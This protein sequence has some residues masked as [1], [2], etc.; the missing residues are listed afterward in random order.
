MKRDNYITEVETAVP[1][2]SRI[3]STTDLK[4]KITHVNQQFCDICGYTQ[5]ELLGHGHNIVRHPQMPKAAFA[6]LWHDI[7]QGKNWMGL[8]KNRRKDGGYYWVNAFITPIRRAG[9]IFEYQSVRTK[10]DKA[11]VQRA[12]A[13]YADIEKGKLPLPKFP[14]SLTAKIGLPWGIS[15]ALLLALPFVSVTIAI[16][17]VILSLLLMSWSLVRLS[18]RCTRLQKLSDDVQQSKLMQAIYTGDTDIL[19]AV[20]LSLR[21]QKAEIVAITA[22]ID[23]TSD[24]LNANLQS[25]QQSVDANHRELSQ[26]AL[27]L[28][29][30][31]AAI[32]Q[33][34]SAIAEIAATSSNT[35]SDV[36]NLE[37]SNQDTM[38]ALEA[39]SAANA[40]MSGLLQKVAS[41]IAELDQQCASVN[42]VLAVIEQLS[43]QT[44]LLALNAAIEAARAGEAGRGFAVVADEVRALAQ[45]SSGSAK[46]I[47]GIIHQ[48]SEQSQQ[49]V[50]EMGKSQTLT[51][52]SMELE[53]QLVTR[54]NDE[55]KALGRITAN[56]HQIAVATEEQAYTVDQLHLNS[57]RLQGGVSKLQENSHEATSHGEELRRQSERQK[58]LIAQFK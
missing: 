19:S 51:Q 28:D 9:K 53:Q 52:H 16:P 25:H 31:A 34:K 5:D 1:V 21:M 43:E 22:R 27:A 23:D 33:M 46:E 26:Q 39:S 37:V 42:T 44:N 30:L 55:A 45:R 11:L 24:H 15:T 49:A 36:T 35:A 41:Q 38:K 3:L 14:L 57:C 58:E 12:I 4:G 48:L 18:A 17:F 13:C 20:E 50:A 6:D 2:D 29:E 10:A 47:Y 54:L 40:E 8:V 32:S 7:Q 56:S